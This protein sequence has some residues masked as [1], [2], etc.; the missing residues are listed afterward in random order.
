MKNMKHLFL[1]AL[2]SLL[3]MVSWGQVG[4]LERSIPEKEACLRRK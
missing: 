4:G 1:C 3:P 2:C